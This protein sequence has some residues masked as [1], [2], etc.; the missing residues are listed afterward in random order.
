MVLPLIYLSSET[1]K[2]TVVE[3]SCVWNEASVSY[4]ILSQRMYFKTGTVLERLMEGGGVNNHSTQ[5]PLTVKK[6][7][8]SLYSALLNILYC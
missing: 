7:Q 2:L 8:I 5:L 3:L 1:F 6:V 4:L